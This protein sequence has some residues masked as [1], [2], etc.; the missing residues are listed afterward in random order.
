M[1]KYLAKAKEYIFGFKSFSNENIPRNKNQKADVLSKLASVA[2][3]HL[4]KEVLVEVLNKRFT[5]RQEVYTIINRGGG[6]LDDGHHT[7]PG[8]R[9]TAEGQK[10]GTVFKSENWSIHHGIRYTIQERLLGS[11]AKMCRSVTSKL[12]HPED[13]TLG[14]CGL[15]YLVSSSLTTKHSWNE[16]SRVEDQGKLGPKW[17]GPYRVVEAYENGSY[18]L[19]TLEDKEVPRTWHAINLRKCYLQLS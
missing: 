12:C 4:T 11:N 18:K 13:P 19:Q 14:S 10:R 15:G 2:F 9:G 6:T 3:N 8:R 1:I 5:E 7:I 17:E 16:A